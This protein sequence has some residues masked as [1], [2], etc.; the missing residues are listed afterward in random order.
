MGTNNGKTAKKQTKNTTTTTT[1]KA[2]SVPLRNELDKHKHLCD[3]LHNVTKPP[4]TQKQLTVSM[5]HFA[6]LNC[7]R[8]SLYVHN[9]QF[10][11]VLEKKGV[12][13]VEFMYLVFTRMPG[14]SYRRR[15]WSLLLCLCDVFRA[16]IK[17]LNS[18]LIL[19]ER[20][21]VLYGIFSWHI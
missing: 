15:P 2:R 14:E 7:A 10:P 17:T 18:V 13:L 12:P 9:Y 11:Q 21:N 8:V 16:L 19:P 1:T 6:R 5:S 3:C 4:T 20:K